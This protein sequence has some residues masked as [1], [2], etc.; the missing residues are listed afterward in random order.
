MRSFPSASLS[1]CLLLAAATFLAACNSPDTSRA[2]SSTPGEAPPFVPATG[3]TD[4]PAASSPGATPGAATASVPAA[5]N[6]PALSTTDS[7]QYLLSPGRVGQ[8]RLNMTEAALLQ[9]V[10]YERMRETKLSIEGIDYPAYELPDPKRPS[11]P[12]LLLEMVGD[13]AEGFRL[14]RVRVRDPR[15]R[16]A[17]GI[18]VGSP[19]GAAVQQYGI[20]T[21]E[22]ADAGLVAVSDQMRMTWMLDAKSVPNLRGGRLTVADIPPATRITG[23]LLF[24]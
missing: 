9:V 12:P 16:T 5:S 22:L 17:E 24:R 20:S 2:P 1:C 15:F 23:V 21:V 3:P 14:W 4:D 10:P 13:S 19:F 8:L 11:A 6:P 7:L 18:G